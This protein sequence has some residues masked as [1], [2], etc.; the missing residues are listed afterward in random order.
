MNE[1]RLPISAVLEMIRTRQ[2][3]AEAGFELIKKLVNYRLASKHPASRGL[4]SAG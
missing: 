1:E 2:I 3:T 4:R